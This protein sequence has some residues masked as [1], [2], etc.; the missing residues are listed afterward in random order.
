LQLVLAGYEPLTNVLD[1]ANLDQDV[2]VIL[3]QTGTG[4]FGRAR[5]VYRDGG[6]SRS[7]AR[8]TILDPGLDVNF[9]K[10][11]MVTGLTENENTLVGHLLEDVSWN[12]LLE[13]STPTIDV[14]YEVGEAQSEDNSCQVGGL[15]TVA[16]ANRDG[17]T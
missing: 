14:A 6:H 17:C 1:Y 4:N 10:D 3:E 8:L 15:F 2:E 5:N 16:K 13:G 11:S 12:G 9:T 7:F